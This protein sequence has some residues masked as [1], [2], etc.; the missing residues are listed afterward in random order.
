MQNFILGKMNYLK[1][2][3][4]WFFDPWPLHIFPLFLTIHIVLINQFPANL[5]MINSISSALFQIIGGIIVLISL[6]SNLNL[7]NKTSIK[8]VFINW[9]KSFPLKSKS[10]ITEVSDSIS[11]QSTVSATATVSNSLNTLEDKIKFLFDEIKRLDQKIS[12]STEKLKEDLNEKFKYI[13]RKH[14][15]LDQSLIEVKANLNNTVLGSPKLEILGILSIIYGL[16]IPVL[17]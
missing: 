5:P 2:L 4:I 7:L 8:N 16:L 1:R 15:N 9:F 13:E 17:Y 10:V 6:N 14:S 11:I 3:F 12:D